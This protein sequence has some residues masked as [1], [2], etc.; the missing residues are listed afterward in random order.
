MEKEPGLGQAPRFQYHT[1]TRKL[2]EPLTPEQAQTFQL[3]IFSTFCRKNLLFQS[4]RLCCSAAFKNRVTSALA[5]FQ[6]IRVTFS[7]RASV[8]QSRSIV[9]D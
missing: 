9:L 3:Q 4:V 7:A 5:S 2:A 1:F 6:S 8:N